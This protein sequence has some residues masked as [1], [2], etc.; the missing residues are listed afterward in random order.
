[1]MTED[2]AKTKQCCGP[3]LVSLSTILAGAMVEK[4]I[5][6]LLRILPEESRCHASECMAWRWH[7][8]R[9]EPPLDQ[10]SLGYCGLAGRPE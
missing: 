4:D 3:P 5:H 1:M 9:G 6:D 8:K 7:W 2:E 10:D